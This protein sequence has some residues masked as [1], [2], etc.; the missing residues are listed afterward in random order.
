MTDDN[1]PDEKDTKDKLSERF[2]NVGGTAL[3]DQEVGGS[4]NSDAETGSSAEETSSA[5]RSHP[6]SLRKLWSNHSFYLSDELSDDLGSEFK[7]LDWQLSNEHGID[8]KKTRHYY[9]L[10]AALD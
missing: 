1:S 6:T 5:S 9:P 4:D 3:S 2:K 8:I 10:I 7:R